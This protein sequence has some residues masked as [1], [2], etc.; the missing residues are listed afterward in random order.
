M[1]SG[2]RKAAR[3]RDAALRGDFGLQ[4]AKPQLQRIGQRQL[5]PQYFADGIEAEPCL[6]QG[7]DQLEAYQVL[8][9][10]HPIAALG[11]RCWRQQSFV[12][13]KAQPSNG[14]AAQARSLADA[15]GPVCHG[16]LVQSPAGGESRG[17]SQAISQDS[18][19]LAPHDTLA[20]DIACPSL[21]F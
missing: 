2:D 14:D 10:I 9:G 7:A 18:I 21:F 17:L 1:S 4:C 6:A 15:V 19:E 3:P 11:P 8:L 12:G 13:I 5:A 16:R 20:R